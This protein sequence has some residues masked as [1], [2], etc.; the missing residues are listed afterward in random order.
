MDT[1]TP[2]KRKRPETK[3]TK[4]TRR[5]LVKQEECLNAPSNTFREI[6]EFPST[7]LLENGLA[8]TADSISI[9]RIGFGTYRLKKEA[10]IAPLATALTCGYNLVDTASIYDNEKQIGQVLSRGNVTPFVISKLWRSHQGSEEIVRKH[11]RD[12]LRKLN[13]GRPLDML[14]LH[15]PGPGEHRF[16]RYQVPESWTPAT[17]LETWLILQSILQEKESSLRSIGVSNFS[18]RHIQEIIEAGAEKPAINQIEMHPFLIQNEMRAFCKMH[19]IQ[20][21]AYGSL[22]GSNKALLK[23]KDVTAIAGECKK[24]PAQVLLRWALQHEVIIIP[25]STNE[26]HLLENIELLPFKLTEKMMKRLDGLNC[27]QRWAW[28]GV[29]PDTVP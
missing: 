10:V 12:S 17:R 1:K 23:H 4:T 5:K 28:K 27:G 6:S 9:P 15:W 13:L 20:V 25:S 18:I 29:D 24:S 11:L 8:P 26:A 14:I 22:G 19:G 21:M 2:S 3:T 7:V 16:K